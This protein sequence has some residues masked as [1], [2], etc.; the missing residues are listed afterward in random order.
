MSSELQLLGVP[1]DP[2]VV[3]VMG[4]G[5]VAKAVP[6][7]D[8]RDLISHHLIVMMCVEAPD[9]LPD[10]F[11]GGRSSEKAKP[12]GSCVRHFAHHGSAHCDYPLCMQP[13]ERNG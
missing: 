1:P 11:N 4:Y 8:H 5:K 7:G 6:S 13:S 9:S 3:K 10:G 2:T 12:N